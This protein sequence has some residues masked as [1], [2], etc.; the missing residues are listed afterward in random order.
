M[1]GIIKKVSTVLLSTIVNISN[2]TKCVL[3]SN[4]K[5]NIQPTIIYLHLN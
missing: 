3:L 4:Q 2:R 5:C 1:F